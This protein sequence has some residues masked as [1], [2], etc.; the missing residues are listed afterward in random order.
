MGEKGMFAAKE[1]IVFG[2]VCIALGLVTGLAFGNFK[3]KKYEI[4]KHELVKLQRNQID[5][6]KNHGTLQ[7]LINTNIKTKIALL[8]TRKVWHNCH[9]KGLD[10]VKFDGITWTKKPNV[11]I[12]QTM[13]QFTSVQTGNIYE[14]DISVEIAADL[15]S[16]KIVFP[17]NDVTKACVIFIPNEAA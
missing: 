11:V 16:Y 13:M 3:N 8:K 2:F 12:G 15:K 17:K 14:A 9:D 10:N 1:I 5:H 7:T 4:Y 6:Q